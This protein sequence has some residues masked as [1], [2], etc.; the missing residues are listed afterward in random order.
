MKNIIILS[1]AI[2]VFAS[3]GNKT[4]NKEEKKDSTS[5]E[6]VKAGG[7]DE[8]KIEAPKLTMEDLVGTWQQT[9]T[10]NNQ[11]VAASGSLTLVLKADGNFTQTIST[12]TNMNMMGIKTP[13][14]SQSGKWSLN[15]KTINLGGLAKLEYHDDTRTLV[16]AAENISLSK[17]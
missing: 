15:D 11:G 9:E 16:N 14:A 8:A 3:C 7:G 1:L 2:A 6:E 5:K 13:S 17:K 10:V 12:S 4:E